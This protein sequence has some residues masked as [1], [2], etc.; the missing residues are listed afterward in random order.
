MLGYNAPLFSLKTKYRIKTHFTISKKNV[1]NCR[2]FQS[3]V[4]KMMHKI[5]T[6]ER[7]RD[8]ETSPRP[9]CVA[10]KVR[11]LMSYWFRHTKMTLNKYFLQGKMENKLSSIIGR[12]WPGG[13]GQLVP[14]NKIHMHIT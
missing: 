5:Q 3:S 2:F 4:T 12:L 10:I 13:Y 7:Y 11:Y 9:Q 14:G 6:I 8:T 1:F